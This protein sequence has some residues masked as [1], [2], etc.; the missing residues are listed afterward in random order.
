MNTRLLKLEV[1]D[2]SADE[3]A[4]RVK[5]LELQL[6]ERDL[7]LNT[8]RNGG[9]SSYSDLK[10]TV[11]EFDERIQKVSESKAQL[12]IKV[13]KEQQETSKLMNALATL[14][15]VHE[16]RETVKSILIDSGI[17]EENAHKIAFDS[18]DDDSCSTES[19]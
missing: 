3:L 5:E 18:F 8:L 14:A 9:E 15:A 1:Q 4:N 19:Q 2:N 12:H 17:S 6:K 7:E 16:D 11:E 10:N 13:L